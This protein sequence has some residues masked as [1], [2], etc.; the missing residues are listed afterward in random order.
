MSEAPPPVSKE[1]KEALTGAAKSNPTGSH[2]AGQDAGSKA[3]TAQAGE[4]EKKVKNEKEC[5]AYLPS[6]R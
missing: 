4:G 3:G 1:T 2:V 5:M 6:H